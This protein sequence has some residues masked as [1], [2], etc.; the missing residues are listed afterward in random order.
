MEVAIVELQREAFAVFVRPGGPDG[1]RRNF[2]LPGPC[3]L[4]NRRRLV[5]Y[6]WPANFPPRLCLTSM[7]RRSCGSAGFL[8]LDSY[9]PQWR[10]QSFRRKARASW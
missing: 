7:S 10:W 1:A 6:E 5:W 2:C 8:A 9:R 3:G 4:R